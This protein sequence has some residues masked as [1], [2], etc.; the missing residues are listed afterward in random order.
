MRLAVSHGDTILVA[1]GVYT[2]LGNRDLDF[3]GTAVA[4]RSTNG[5]AECI[6]DFAVHNLQLEEVFRLAHNSIIERES[7]ECKHSLQR[8]QDF[9]D[10]RLQM[11]A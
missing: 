7:L 8:L 11:D 9:D 3:H 4:L 2:G 10:L 6:I 5:P 1:D